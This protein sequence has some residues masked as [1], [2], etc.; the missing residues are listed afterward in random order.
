M[1]LRPSSRELHDAPQREEQNDDNGGS[2]RLPFILHNEHCNPYRYGSQ[3]DGNKKGVEYGRVDRRNIVIIVFFIFIGGI[4]MLVKGPIM[5]RTY[6]FSG[7]Y[8]DVPDRC[9]LK[10]GWLA[11]SRQTNLE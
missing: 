9:S 10:K 8:A 3:G 11:D 5:V 2:H 1:H 7:V 6:R 4:P